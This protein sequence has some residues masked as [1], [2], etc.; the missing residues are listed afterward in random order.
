M[1]PHPHCGM[2]IAVL[3]FLALSIKRYSILAVVMKTVRFLFA[4]LLVFTSARGQGTINLPPVA[5]TNGLTGVL[6]DAG[7]VAALYYGPFGAADSGLLMLSA[8]SP[9][10]GGYARF[11]NGV[12]LPYGVGATAELE[13]RAWSAPYPTYESAAAS[14]LASVL[15]G[16]SV[17]LSVILG[18]SPGPPPVPDPLAFPGFTVYPVPEASPSGLL[19]FGAT[20]LLLFRR[21][22]RH[23]RR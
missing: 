1:C 23:A 14:D 22:L 13:V 21:S 12:V 2:A 18:G 9:L 16:K 19:T 5:V 6:A 7:I 20:T 11:G 4:A 8:P 15:A 3:I 17:M 10:V